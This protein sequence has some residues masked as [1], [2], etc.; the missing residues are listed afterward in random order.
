MS[1]YFVKVVDMAG[2]LISDD[3]AS[4]F[5]SPD[6]TLL[7]LE[8]NA[9]G[10]CD[11]TAATIGDPS[12][13][14]LVPTAEVQIIRNGDVY[15]WGV[16]VRPQMGLRTST[17]QCPGLLWYLGRRYIGKAD[18]TNL[19]LDGD[20]EDGDSA[21][22][23]TAGLTHAVSTDQAEDGTHSERLEASTAEHNE[24]ASQSFGPKPAG[25][26]PLGD[27]ITV[28]AFVYVPSAD[29]D[30]PA[31]EGR[32]LVVIH[33]DIDGNLLP[34]PEGVRSDGGTIDETTLKGQW[35][36]LQVEV[37]FVKEGETIEVRLYPPQGVAYYDLVT[38]TLMESVYF[39]NVDAA[40][41]A[42]KLV[43][44]AQDQLPGFTHG[45]SDLNIDVDTPPCGVMVTRNYLLSEH[46][47]ILDA[48]EELA[49]VGGFDYSVE[50]TETTRTFTTFAPRKGE[51]KE[52]EALELDANLSDFQW[53]WDGQAATTDVV[54]TGPGDGPGRPE[55]G[56]TNPTA[57]DGLTLETVE[58]AGENALVREL[59]SMAAD[60]LATLARPEVVEATTYPDGSAITGLSVGDT[61]PILIACGACQVDGTYRVVKV[62]VN[63]RTDQATFTLNPEPP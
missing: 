8:L 10:S 61:V 59:D 46:R 44:Y 53:S 38:A 50:I 12:A 54:V 22:D 21:W 26:H 40:E 27:L 4:E 3:P 15:F 7:E 6:I 20:F 45:K 34:A 11:I 47:N 28:N 29:Y 35:V 31:I 58:S 39:E 32:G 42:G 48:I 49:A 17:F 57:F 52:D 60:I 30:G 33:K 51:L 18:R 43:L 5:E 9:P 24:Y 19:L 1:D 14:Y 56:A 36:P 63:T 37:P 13:D 25:G 23:F 16:V 2:A 55:G 41:V 62:S